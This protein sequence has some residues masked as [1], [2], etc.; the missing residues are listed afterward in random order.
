M[1]VLKD[2]TIVPVPLPDGDV[3]GV[4]TVTQAAH[5]LWRWRSST[6][7]LPGGSAW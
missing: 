4:W 2:S 6:D 5:A 1:A 7:F 3:V